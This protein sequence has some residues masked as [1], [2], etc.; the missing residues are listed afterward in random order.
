MVKISSSVHTKVENGLELR[1]EILETALRATELTQ[2]IKGYK[3]DNSEKKKLILK[4]K[5]QI[6][7]L[8]QVIHELEFKDLPREF[9]AKKHKVKDIIKTKKQINKEV[10][11][12][13]LEQPIVKSQLETELD[14]L[15][16]K[17]NKIKV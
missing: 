1:K 15:R 16:D 9:V 10:E 6:T 3:K 5:Q 8:K 2:K 14:F 12:K 17:I 13:I 11:E 4:F 7:D